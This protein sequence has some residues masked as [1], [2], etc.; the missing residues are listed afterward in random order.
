MILTK[1]DDPRCIE[2]YLLAFPDK[3]IEYLEKLRINWINKNCKV[4]DETND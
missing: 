4:K 1:E 2:F 3:D